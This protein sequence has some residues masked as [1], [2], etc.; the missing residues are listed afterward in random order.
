MIIDS[1]IFF[2]EIQ[3]LEV[4]LNELFDICDYFVIVESAQTFAGRSKTYTFL[5]HKEKFSKFLHKIIYFQIPKLPPIIDDTEENRFRLEK[6][7]RDRLFDAITHVPNID[8]NDIVLLGDADEI[9]SIPG[10]LRAAEL[11]G[12]MD[13]VSF[14]Q[15]HYRGS[16]NG[17]VT[18]E[19]DPW[20]GTI[21]FKYKMF[22][23]FTPDELRFEARID[24][25]NKGSKNRKIKLDF[26]ENGGW[27]FSY[28][29]GKNSIAWKV[30]SFS[31]GAQDSVVKYNQ[32]VSEVIQTL[33]ADRVKFE[34]INKAKSTISLLSEKIPSHILH[35]PEKYINLIIGDII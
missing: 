11:L 21:A 25:F 4:R 8:F 12:G 17:R 14:A 16:L 18:D 28:F 35:N 7:Q 19:W 2:N 1:F 27:H 10:I 32:N 20:P 9:P 15:D 34:D 13:L 23:R 26:A 31:H 30:S 22:S 29:G 33:D 24:R 3:L 5:E 6:F